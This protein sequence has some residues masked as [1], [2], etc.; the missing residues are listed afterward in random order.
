[1]DIEVVHG[2]KKKKA[3]LFFYNFK[4]YYITATRIASR[5]SDLLRLD[6]PGFETL[7]GARIFIPS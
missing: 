1:M 6:G 2:K 4:V 7:W 3:S 5:Y